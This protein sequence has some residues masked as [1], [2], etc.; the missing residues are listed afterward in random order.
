MLRCSILQSIHKSLPAMLVSLLVVVVATTTMIVASAEPAPTMELGVESPFAVVP[1]DDDGDGGC[2]IPSRKIRKLKAAGFVK[3]VCPFG[4]VL[5]AGTESYPDEYLKYGANVLANILD[6][7]ADGVADDP[8][9]VDQLDY[10]TSEGGAMLAC[11][12]SPDEEER[13]YML[14]DVFDYTFSCQTWHAWYWDETDP[15]ESVFKGVMMEEAF[16]M[17]YQNGYAVVYP[18]QLG[19]DDYTS[20]VVGRETDRLQCAE[21]GWIHPENTCPDTPRDP[22]DPRISPLEGTCNYP[23]CDIAEFYKMVLFLLIGMGEDDTDPD[24]PYLWLSESMPGTRAEVEAILTEEFLGMVADPSLHQ[25]RVPLTGDYSASVVSDAPAPLTSG[26][27]HRFDPRHS[28]DTGATAFAL[29]A[30]LLVPFLV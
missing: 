22:D 19:M 12:M 20:S 10:R 23:S 29:E 27:S 8:S 6:Q 21:P 26:S 4:A 15:S 14:E 17:V 24:G 3:A 1:V 18:D 28:R 2:A 5:I 25:L 16:H 11:G 9:V 13:E 30:I 7:D